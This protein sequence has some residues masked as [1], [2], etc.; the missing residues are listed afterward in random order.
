MRTPFPIDR[1]GTVTGQ[2]FQRICIVRS[3][4]S[5]F[6]ILMEQGENVFDSWF[7]TDADVARYLED[8]DVAWDG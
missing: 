8:I 3:E 2:P 1:W 7:E 5:C 4:G 6:L